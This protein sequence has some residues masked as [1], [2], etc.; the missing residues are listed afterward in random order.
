MLG[1]SGGLVF[2]L[3]GSSGWNGPGEDWKGGG[4]ALQI[5]GDHLGRGVGEDLRWE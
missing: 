2:S 1:P 5:F 3:T 4:V